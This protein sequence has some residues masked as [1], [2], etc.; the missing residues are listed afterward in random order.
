[1]EVTFLEVYDPLSECR[2]DVGISDIPLLWHSPVEDWRAAWH[3]RRSQGDLVLDH[4]QGTP[5]SVASDTPANRKKLA[6]KLETPA[7]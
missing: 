6:R 7:R 5:H 2:S 1:M 4:R 3:L